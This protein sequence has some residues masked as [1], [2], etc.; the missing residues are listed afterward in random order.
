MV[1]NFEHHSGTKGEIHQQISCPPSEFVKGG[2]LVF[3]T[4]ASSL[5]AAPSNKFEVRRVLKFEFRSEFEFEFEDSED[6]SVCL[7][8][9][10]LK[11]KRNFPTLA[12]IYPR[13][14]LLI[15]MHVLF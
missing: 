6:L 5:F 1:C 9:L 13:V 7:F 14:R 12:R 15:S 2:R 8:H 10:A 3:S 4:R 11:T